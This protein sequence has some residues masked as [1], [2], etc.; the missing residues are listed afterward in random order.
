MD[1]D[2]I[3]SIR[4]ALTEYLRGFDACMGRAPN[5]THLD[6]YVSGQLSNLQRK[7]VEPMADAAGVAPRT[8]Q[9]FLSLL[10]KH[11]LEFDSKDAWG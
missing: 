3:L 7:S 5:R 8:L 10:R 4:P 1:A 6:T 11:G 9:E 2:T